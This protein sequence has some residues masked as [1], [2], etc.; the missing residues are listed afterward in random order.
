M[1]AAPT[2]FGGAGNP[3][4]VCRWQ[5]QGDSSGYL[6]TTQS[7]A[8]AARFL[9]ERVGLGRLCAK[10]LTWISTRA[11]PSL[12]RVH[13]SGVRCLRHVSPL[14]FD[15]SIPRFPPRDPDG[16]SSPGSAVLSGRNDFPPP[17]SHEEAAFHGIRPTFLARASGFDAVDSSFPMHWSIEL[18]KPTQRCPVPMAARLEA[19]FA[20]TDSACRTSGNRRDGRVWPGLGRGLCIRPPFS[21]SHCSRR[22]CSEVNSRLRPPLE[23][24]R[25][26]LSDGLHATHGSQRP[27]QGFP[28]RAAQVRTP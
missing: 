23:Y 22:R 15:N 9:P 8:F 13:G 16:A 20:P 18:A 6:S 12:S 26:R 21:I 4:W 17:L 3:T 28:R 27:V 10:C 11:Y 24:A 2:V 7:G 14:R 19:C 5:R 25:I 1:T